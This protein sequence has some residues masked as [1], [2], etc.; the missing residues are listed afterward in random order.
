MLNFW[1]RNQWLT[2]TAK[3]EK[4]KSGIG[5][6]H[7]IFEPK[8]EP[9]ITS[10]KLKPR[11]SVRETENIIVLLTIK[12]G[13]PASSINIHSHPLLLITN[14]V[15][16]KITHQKHSKMGEVSI[17]HMN[18]GEGEASYAKNS[19]CQVRTLI[20]LSLSPCCLGYKLI[21][22]MCS[23]RSQHSQYIYLFSHADANN[24]TRQDRDGE[25]SVQS[26]RKQSPEEHGDS[27]SRLLLGAQHFDG[28]FRDNRQC[29]QNLSRDRTPDARAE[30]GAERS[31]RQ[32]LQLRV[33]VVARVLRQPQQE[34][35]RRFRPLLHIRHGR[36]LLR[37]TF[38]QKFFAFCSLLIQPSLALSG[39]I[40]RRLSEFVIK[41]ERRK[42]KNNNKVYVF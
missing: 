35:G 13:P 27:R 22:H 7:Q 25:G 8:L 19:T 33:H 18:K 16:S 24:I 28:G 15:I 36:L 12:K 32:R 23:R 6:N 1:N 41:G 30:G 3:T 39:K 40:T 31:P 2:K 26:D 10:S 4:K 37:Q 9:S 38:S 34:Q 11:I 20:Y 14:F 21:P 29:P 17:L 42:K 5:K